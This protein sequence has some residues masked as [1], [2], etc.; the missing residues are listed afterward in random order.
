[1]L[2]FA[3]L[4]QALHNQEVQD[5]ESR[6]DSQLLPHLMFAVGLQMGSKDK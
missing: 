6:D 5:T 2:A 1:M 4:S 3:T